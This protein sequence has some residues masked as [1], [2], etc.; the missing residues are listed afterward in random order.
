MVLTS[1]SS[2]RT[3]PRI[4]WDCVSRVRTSYSLATRAAESDELEAMS[5]PDL[6]IAC[7]RYV[8][9]GLDDTALDDLN[10]DILAE[11]RRRGDS[12]PSGTWLNERFAL[13]PCFINPRGG[14]DDAERLVDDVLEIGRELTT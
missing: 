10:Q 7:F 4:R 14:L 5:Q 2:H 9:P 12:L 11:L 8:V 1:P 13:R 3:T 6:S